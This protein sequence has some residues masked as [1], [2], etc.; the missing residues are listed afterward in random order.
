MWPT[1]RGGR[2]GLNSARLLPTTT[3]MAPDVKPV[4]HEGQDVTIELGGACAP[5]QGQVLGFVG[6]DVIVLL[7]EELRAGLH[8]V[9]GSAP[10]GYLVISR[11]RELSALRG[12]MLLTD[13]ADQLLVR[14]TDGFRLGQRRMYS[15]APLEVAVAAHGLDRSGEPVDGTGWRTWTLDLSAGGARV[16]RPAGFV[17]VPQLSLALELPPGGTSVSVRAVVL[18]EDAE[19]LRLRFISVGPEARLELMRAVL[20][21]QRHRP[22]MRRPRGARPA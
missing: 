4:L 18:R 3:G 6:A 12:R 8:D 16:V 5:L 7:A 14:V 1:G 15:R 2:S 21:C 9:L 20:R 17:P 13:A 10:L 22:A 11:G 19:A